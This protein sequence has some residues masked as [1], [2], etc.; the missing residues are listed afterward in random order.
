MRS[1]S[2]RNG[3]TTRI[4]P[5]T[6][7]RRSSRSRAERP[8]APTDRRAE[9]RF[10]RSWRRRLRLSA[11]C[12]RR[13]GPHRALAGRPEPRATGQGI[14]HEKLT[15]SRRNVAITTTAAEMSG[16]ELLTRKATNAHNNL[17]P[18]IT[19]SQQ[20]SPCG[21]KVRP[22][23]TPRRSGGATPLRMRQERSL[24]SRPCGTPSLRSVAL[25]P[26]SGVRRSAVKRSDGVA[27][28]R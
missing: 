10:K 5:K 3:P 25:D 4:S 16:L 24:R 18:F 8:I 6:H 22:R 26:C 13:G 28:L 21:S 19:S 17:I 9:R 14:G 2:A 1:L 23:H 7:V 12:A 20:P 15:M 27:S 11:P